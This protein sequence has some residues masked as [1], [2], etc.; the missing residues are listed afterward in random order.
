MGVPLPPQE[1]L[2]TSIVVVHMGAFQLP[3]DT[4]IQT[5]LRRSYHITCCV[6]NQGA[7]SAVVLVLASAF[8]KSATEPKNRLLKCKHATMI[9]TFN[10]RTL[11]K[12]NQISELTASATEQNIDIICVQEHWLYH[13]DVELK[14][15]DC[16]SDW[17]F[18]SAS[19]WKNS[20]NST[21]GG[22]DI[23]LSP[24]AIRFLNSIE[25]IN[26]RIA[27]FNGNPYTATI[28]CHSPTNVS[29]ESDETNF[30]NSRSSLVH[31]VP[32]H[33]VLI[34]GGDM[35]SKISQSLEHKFAYHHETYRNGQYLMNVIT[36]NGLVC[37]NT[38]F[39]KKQSK[40]WTHSY[41]NGAKVQL[42]YM[43]V[44][45]KWINSV[46]HSEAYSTFEGVSSDHRIV[47][48]KIRF[49][50]RANK[51]KANSQ[52]QYD[53]SVLLNS[54][55]IQNQYIITVK[56]RFESLQHEADDN[57]PNATYESFVTAHSDTAEACIPLKPKRKRR[58]PWETTVV[59]EKRE[60][61]KK[62]AKTRNTYPTK[63]NI[64]AF[65]HAQKRLT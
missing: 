31:Q 25:K 24:I 47:T 50:L 32:E 42:D 36:E 63:S 17:T 43:F 60:H 38:K 12:I 30:Y 56:N 14:H 11:A 10:V 45:R 34:I 44:N 4:M 16:G 62:L 61:L 52:P 46:L 27:T 54:E 15:Y 1:L 33:N 29:D 65:K 64:A 13:K 19:A 49:S 18:I 37:L 7:H 39:Q 26:L 22:V 9:S 20:T 58:V 57:I 8:Q 41:P 59:T 5:Q 40:L 51:R 21:I 48:T 23:L 53:W 6:G 3:K 2:L 28:S 35:N 55:G